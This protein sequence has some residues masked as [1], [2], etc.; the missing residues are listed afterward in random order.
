MYLKIVVLSI[1]AM[2]V[3][4]A[5]TASTSTFS[6]VDALTVHL[7]NANQTIAAQIL[8][9]S[10]DVTGTTCT[11]QAGPTRDPMIR[12]DYVHSP[13]IGSHK[14]HT[15]AKNW[16]DARKICNDENAHLA[17]I[18]SEAEEAVSISGILLIIRLSSDNTFHNY[19]DIVADTRGDAEES[20]E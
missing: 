16:N 18:N 7:C 15:D 1:V 6:A 14:I 11:C 9:K 10:S 19:I 12:E 17:I 3:S 5:T 8:T 4:E 13:G 20:R 2:L